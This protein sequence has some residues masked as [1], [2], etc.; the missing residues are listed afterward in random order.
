MAFQPKRF[1]RSTALF[2]LN[3]EKGLVSLQR[4]LSDLSYRHGVYRSFFIYDPKRRLI[5]AAPYRDRVVHHA[6]CNVIEPL[7]DK[8]FIYDSYAC[9]SRARKQQTSPR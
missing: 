2:N 9:R 6:L 4:E 7:F 8:A 1:K 3:L 5:S